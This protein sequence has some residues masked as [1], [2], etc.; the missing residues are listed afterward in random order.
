MPALPRAK[1]AYRLD[2]VLFVA[3]L[4]I[5]IAPIW[6]FRYFPSTDGPAHLENAAIL[7]EYHDP[8][9]QLY[10]DF[11]TINTRPEPNW[12]GHLLLAGLLF[13]APPLVA[14]K[15]VLTGYLLL[16]PLSARYAMRSIR[17]DAGFVALLAFPFVPNRFFHMGF[18]NFCY[19]FP[20]FFFVVGYWLR[21]RMEFTW[22]RTAM[23]GL[24]G[25]LLYF[26]HPFGLAAWL[27]IGVQA[28]WL[29][30][31]ELNAKSVSEG[32][33]LI[34]LA[35]TLWSNI[36]AP[37]WAVL[38]TTLLALWF[39]TRPGLPPRP[40]EDTAANTLAMFLKLEVLVSYNIAEGVPAL[41]LSLFLL[42][43]LG[44]L[45]TAWMK[46]WRAQPADGLLL[47]AFGFVVLLLVMPPSLAG[48]LFV[49]QRLTLYAPFTLLLWFAAQPIIDRCRWP[50]RAAAV[51]ATLILVGLFSMTY[52]RAN[53]YLGEMV[54]VADAIEPGHTL[55]PL[56]F[57]LPS[58]APDGQ[59]VSAGVPL[60]QHVDGYLAAQRHLVSLKNYEATTGYFP[61]LYRTE[62]NP[63]LII[64]RDTKVLDGGLHSVPPRVDILAYEAATGRAIDYVLIWGVWSEPPSDPA[65]RA[66]MLQLKKGGYEEVHL[67]SRHG[68][69]HL[70]RHKNCK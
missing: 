12:L 62:M 5:E 3:L 1:G 66:I 51:A 16:L 20:L 43:T 48:G 38:P 56:S 23:L 40:P 64:G 50:I 11:Y 65:S 46:V 19:S 28:L 36:A 68:L 24:L 70:Y 44:Y 67:A 8:D 9:R 30:Y 59:P 34:G 55:L 15:I 2:T 29:T 63:Y 47:A 45:L 6:Y 61:I 7:R 17:P 33:R 21:H 57:I 14:E 69:A 53:S 41:G 32:P 25:L 37:F 27:V 58:H 54:E 35:K 22:P 31:L 52:I 49:N 39:L 13:V 60:F 10:R 26:C 4:A 42:G 18:H